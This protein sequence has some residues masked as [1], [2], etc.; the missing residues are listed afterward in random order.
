MCCSV[1]MPPVILLRLL[2]QY[3][4]LLF[5]NFFSADNLLSGAA[6]TFFAISYTFSHVWLFADRKGL[7]AR[8]KWLVRTFMSGVMALSVPAICL[9]MLSFIFLFLMSQSWRSFLSFFFFPSTQRAFYFSNEF[10]ASLFKDNGFN[11][12]EIDLCCK[13]VENR[14]RELLMN[15]YVILIWLRESPVAFVGMIVIFCIWLQTMDPSRI[16]PFRCWGPF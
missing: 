10:L 1:I 11:V 8:I 5:R 14:S 9:W 13:Q 2:F 15:R 16:L 7:L 12:K 3:T 4:I 6:H